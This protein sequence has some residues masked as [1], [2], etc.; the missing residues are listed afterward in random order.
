MG[1]WS[2]EANGRGSRSTHP[3]N[4]RLWQGILHKKGYQRSLGECQR[5][6]QDGDKL[7]TTDLNGDDV[8]FEAQ[9]GRVKEFLNKKDVKGAYV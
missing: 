4:L 7:T 9:T 5:S 3:R 8:E 2:R 1:Q 6:P